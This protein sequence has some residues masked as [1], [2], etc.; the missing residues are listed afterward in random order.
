MGFLELLKS[1]V[2]KKGWDYNERRGKVRVNCRIDASLLK[3]QALIGI[4]IQNISVKGMLL[5]CLGKVKKGDLVALKGVK[6]YNQAEVHQVNCRVEWV[7]KKT[8]GWQ[9][10][11]TFLDS[12]QD[13]SRSWLYWEM[14]EQ[15]LRMVGADQRRE[16]FRVRTK[17]PA[18]VSVESELRKAQIVNLS[19][20]GAQVQI[21]GDG[22]RENQVVGLTFGPLEELPKVGVSA[23]VASLHVEGAPVYGLRFLN[24]Q[25]GTE[26]DMRRYL[27]FFFKS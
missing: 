17:I 13:M 27:D 22:L 19:N 15:N 9:A 3:G 6:Q 8:P 18:K 20:G 7:E 2:G 12:M 16:T 23:T 21:M 24:Y 14:K 5:M 1:L 10:G 26:D 4:Q 11:V 25:V